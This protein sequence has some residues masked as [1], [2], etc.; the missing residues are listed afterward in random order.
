MPGLVMRRLLAA[1]L[2]AILCVAQPVVAQSPSPGGEPL[3]NVG[4]PLS[5]TELEETRTAVGMTG[6]QAVVVADVTAVPDPPPSA[7]TCDPVTTACPFGRLVGLSGDDVVEVTARADATVGLPAGITG[8]LVLS[9][10]GSDVE[11]LGALTQL[12]GYTV[13]MDQASFAGAD[14]SA[15]G[16]LIAVDGWLQVL[17]WGVP[18]PAPR[19]GRTGDSP[20]VRCPAGWITAQPFVPGNTD[21]PAM[22]PPGF[23]VPVQAS[24]Y[25]TFAPDP[26]RA[27]GRAS[28]PLPGAAGTPQRGIYLLRHVANPIAGG[29]PAVGWLVIARLDT[30]D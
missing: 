26:V 30:I 11:L 6:D 7:P 14:S 28:P 5:I 12:G 21:N 15:V 2:P 17:G 24:A 9:L 8:S 3:A 22:E 13:P 4:R 23:G 1:V 25:A 10:V 16:T 27:P 29:V 19:G 18:C 20:F